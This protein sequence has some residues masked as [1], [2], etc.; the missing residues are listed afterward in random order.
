MVNINSIN[1]DTLTLQSISP[2]DVSIIPNITITSSFSP[3]NDRIEYFVYDFNNNL[4]SSN[5]DLRLYKPTLIDSEGNIVDMTINPETDIIA[6]GYD[7]GIVKT[8][9]N[10]ISPQFDSENQRLYISEISSTR[11]EVR[12]SSNTNPLFQPDSTVDTFISSSNYQ[13]YNTFRQNVESNNY[14]DEFYLDFGNNI[15][16]ICVNSVLEFDSQ[17]NTISL[18]VKLYEPLP[19]DIGLKTEL[20][21]VTKKAESIAYQIEF[22]QENI[23]QDTTLKLSGPNYNIP[24]KDETGPLTQYKTYEDIVTTTLSGSYFQLLN[25]ISSSS[26]ELSVDYTNYEDFIF[27]SSAYQRLYNFQQKVINISSS[28]AQLNLLYSNISGPSVN[29]PAVSS[30]KLLLEKE[31]Q[32]TI[33]SFDGYENFLY[34][35]SGTYAWPKSN[36]VAPYVLYPPTS[37]QVTNWYAT[38]SATASLYDLNNQNNLDYVVPEYIRYNTSNTNYM[39][40]TNLIGQ[41]F[42]EIWLYTKAITSKLDANSNLYEGVSKDLVATV[43][44]SLGTKIYDST[45]TLEN[46][47]SSLIGLSANGSIYPS[48]GSALITNYVTAS[49]PNT[50]DIPTINDFVKLSYKKIYHNLPYLLKKKGTVAGLRTLINIFGIP[51]TILQINEFGGKNKIGNNDWDYWQDKFNYK[52]DVTGGQDS[53]IVTPWVANPNWNSPNNVPQTIQ[54]R[55]KTPGLDS[56][57]T[58][59]SQ[60]LWN[61]NNSGQLA[62]VLEYTGSGYTSGSYSGSITS[63]FSEYATLKF[64]PNTTVDENISASIYLPFFNGDWWS[65]MVTKLNDNF[66]L[67]A[68]NK[69]YNGDDGYIIGYTGS[70]TASINS[71]PWNGG[72]NSLFGSQDQLTVGSKTY[73]AFSGSY[74]EIRY[75]RRV[76]P[77]GA[78]YDYTM[79]PSSIE[80]V[81][82]NGAYD[83]LMFRGA[84][85]SELYTGSISIHPKI[86]GSQITQSFTSDSNFTISNGDFTTNKEFVFQDQIPAGVRNTVSKK[87]K[88]V[89]TILPYSGSNEVNLPTNT[90]LSPFIIIDQESYNSSSY[91]ADVDYVEVAFSPQNEINEDINAQIGYFNIGDYIGDPRLV[92]SSA[93]SYPEL[94]ILRDAYFQKYYTNYNLWDYIRIIQYYDNALFKMIKDYVPV[95]SSLTTGIVIKQHI[96]ERNKYPVPQASISTPIAN[97]GINDFTS[98]LFIPGNATVNVSINYPLTSSATGL[99]ITGSI[100]EDAVDSTYF[101]TL[102]NPDAVQLAELFVG[103]TTPLSTLPFN[104]SYIG[105]IPS[106]SYISFTAD[107]G[108]GNYQINNFTASLYTPYYAPYYTENM[109]ITGSPIQMVEVQGTTGG[110]MPNLF[111]LTSSEYTGN[112]IVNITQSWTGSTPSLLGPVTF[113]DST[114]IEFFNGE[115]SGSAILTDNAGELNPLNPYKNPDTTYI[116]YDFYQ[117][118]LN[119]DDFNNRTQEGA[120][121]ALTPGSGQIFVYNYY[122]G[123]S[124]SGL[125][126]RPVY[127]NKWILVSK[128]SSNGLDLEDTLGALE[129]LN[130]AGNTVMFSRK[131]NILSIQERATYFIFLVAPNNLNYSLATGFA[132]VQGES[133]GSRQTVFEPYDSTLF[134]NSEFNPLIDNALVS[135]PNANFFDVDFSSNSITAVN[136]NTIISASRRT[137]SATPSTVPE[138]NYTTARIVNPRYDG[139]LNTSPDFN[140]GIGNLPPVVETDQTYF[141]YFDWVGGTTPEIIPKT[142]AHVLYLIGEDG[143]ILTPNSSGSYYENL[144]RTFNEQ[145][146]VNVIFQAESA[147]GNI[148]TLQGVKP[149]I[150]AGA[151]AQAIIFSQTG[152]NP[153][154]NNGWLTTMSFGASSSPYDYNLKTA[155]AGISVGTNA[156]TLLPLTTPATS[157]STATI[158]SFAGDYVQIVNSDPNIQIKP[159]LN[160]QFTYFN[161]TS[162]NTASLVLNIQSSTDGNNWTNFYIS[163]SQLTTTGIYNVTLTPDYTTQ[164]VANTYFRG[165]ITY[166]QANQQAITSLT[167]NS[168][169]IF[170]TQT[171][172]TTAFVTSSY[173]QTGSSSQNVITGSQFNVELYGVTNQKEVS[174]AGYDYPYQP[175]VIQRGDQIRFSGDENQ[176]Y[177][178]LDVNAPSQNVSNSLYLSLDK[179]ITSGTNLNSF[180]IKRFVNNPNVVIF[181]ADKVSGVGN[182]PG[183]LMPEYAS[184]TLLDKFDIIVQDLTAKGII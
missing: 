32:T 133:A 116:A 93:E 45:Y 141:A 39:L 95:R 126:P 99:S 49:V 62:L 40:F 43:L 146:K 109:E 41:F 173:W 132:G 174:G 153:N 60:S 125:F 16:V 184:Q 115:L 27:F 54:L 169:N 6:A 61:L 86:T 124:S 164:A 144:T 90:V 160:V 171:P 128:T 149:V 131:F 158:A 121:L 74:Q 180:L 36:A 71:D 107:P 82:I 166:I 22:T 135:R 42:D 44:E 57:L 130:I 20:Y 68:A 127:G 14:F 178:I 72:I 56:A 17:N 104:G 172:P 13:L 154:G 83:Q 63:S 30:S 159:K 34:Y 11:T 81:G 113:V 10:F 12:L 96:L 5:Y 182:G 58:Y 117:Y 161:F 151:L 47:Y 9:Y 55:F 23:F 143:L 28:Q 3:V 105:S 84:L 142:A 129:E 37:T 29:T 18:L 165:Q 50:E 139:C 21:V 70:S 94:N 123:N 66:V 108:A 122:D 46:I 79:N 175:F 35:T 111:G 157:A 38:Q 31:I 89:T 168:G 15:Y 103:T 73:D 119:V 150:K 52:L 176:L 147:S 183:F 19:T 75:Y 26:P 87:I 64:I 51:D 85:G 114:Q 65:V 48:T 181:D 8:I 88:N 140:I 33:S 67:H 148:S 156:F 1:P 69:I 145:Q 59:N 179:N 53:Y 162:N 2:E 120:F 4:L 25:N 91:V 152:S 77:S 92:S 80:G 76:I 112:G 101:I 97:I 98:S 24:L 136:R 177:Q 155:I 110:T 78:F 167:V 134:V 100:T 106:G 137:G 163:A 118:T 102:Y 7:T 170:L 138:S